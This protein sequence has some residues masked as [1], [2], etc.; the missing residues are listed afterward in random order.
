MFT[1]LSHVKKFIT[2]VGEI[3]AKWSDILLNF[4]S[5]K[6]PLHLNNSDGTNNMCSSYCVAGL[7]SD[8]PMYLIFP[9]WTSFFSSPIYHSQKNNTAYKKQSHISNYARTQIKKRSNKRNKLHCNF[10]FEYCSQ[11]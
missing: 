2:L 10:F 1:N 7:A 5:P 11:T 9:S 4:T 8:N 6:G 3:P